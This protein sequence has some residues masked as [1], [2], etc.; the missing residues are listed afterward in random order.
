MT[1]LYSDPRLPLALARLAAPGGYEAFEDPVRGARFCRRPVRLR[2][3][4]VQTMTDGTRRVL[5]DSAGQPDRVLL[6]ACGTRRQTLCPPCAS[7]YRGDAFALVAAGLRG[8]KGIPDEVAS[9]PAV[10]LT[11]TA[12]SFGVVHRTARDGT[13]HRSGPHCP[14]GNVLRC[15]CRHKEDDPV[16][17]QALCGA[18]YDYDAAVLFNASVSELWRRTTI[19]A[20]RALGNLAGMSVRAV[21]KEV[22]LSYV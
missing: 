6:K 21:A 18:C 12:P 5:F 17:G 20:L 9:H 16:L 15:G 14:H 22:R 8:G 13:C 7:I 2:G 4:V 11:L 19:Y 1:D 10:L 3:S